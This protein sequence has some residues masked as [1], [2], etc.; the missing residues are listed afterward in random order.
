MTFDEE[1][2]LYQ[3]RCQKA[4][5][6]SVSHYFQ[7]LSEVS[8]AAEYALMNGGKRVRGVLCLSSCQLLE[9]NAPQAEAYA[10]AVEMVHAFSLVHDDL[11]CMDDDD[12]RRGKPATHIAFGEATA[13]LAG[14]LLS[15]QAFEAI[16]KGGGEAWQGLEAVKTL[17]MAAGARGMIYGQELDLHYETQKADE[18]ALYNIHR[19]KTG[20]LISA[21][22]DLGIIAS[23]KMPTSEIA[24]QK[25]A[26]NL[27]LVFQ[28]VD[29]LLDVTSNEAELGK[30]VGSDRQQGKST[31]ITILGE[32]KARR[33]IC[34]LT[35]EGVSALE[36]AYG[37][38][39]SFLCEYAN[40]LAS[41][42]F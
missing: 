22:V 21:S 35:E 6:A 4:L 29:D 32:E 25:F 28:I 23:G 9:G 14:D 37:H 5:E 31:F 33:E 41:R 3:Q 34:R 42:S 11:P 39:A 16:A 1:H 13:L 19:H 20:A 26:E 12:L 18:Q 38:R 7:P 17:V 27:G 36:A 10:T 30:P 8:R 24:L 2:L 15:L 40:T